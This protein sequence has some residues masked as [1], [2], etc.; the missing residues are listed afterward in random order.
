MYLD[1][2][3]YKADYGSL[4]LRGLEQCVFYY[5]IYNLYDWS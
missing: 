2:P 1:H 3:V 4:Q 5:H